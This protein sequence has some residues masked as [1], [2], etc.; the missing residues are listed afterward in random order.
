MT[1]AT[2]N[3]LIQNVDND[4]RI[5]PQKRLLTPLLLDKRIPPIPSEE[6]RI[7]YPF[8]HTSFFNEMFFL[9]CFPVLKKGYLR[10]LE[11]EDL[12]KVGNELDIKFM[13]DRIPNSCWFQSISRYIN[14]FKSIVIKSFD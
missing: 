4:P 14:R 12:Y 9:W 11:P 7:Y 10:T 13:T 6:E 1:S 2:D 3:N 8:R 5:K